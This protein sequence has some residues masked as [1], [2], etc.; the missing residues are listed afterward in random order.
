MTRLT[1]AL[2]EPEK[3]RIAREIRPI[4]LPSRQVLLWS[5]DSCLHTYVVVPE[6]AQSSRGQ[7]RPKVPLHYL[8]VNLHSLY[9]VVHYFTVFNLP[10][11]AKPSKCKTM[12]ATHGKRPSKQLLASRSGWLFGIAENAQQWDTQTLKK[13]RNRHLNELFI[14]R[15]TT[16]PVRESDIIQKI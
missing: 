5:L 11:R 14:I 8:F 1:S 6:T 15:S 3:S 12:T 13:N 4:R 7:T 10:S 16:P 2:I 9:R